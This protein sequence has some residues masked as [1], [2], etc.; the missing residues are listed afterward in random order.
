MSAIDVEKILSPVSEA[1][2]CGEDFTYNPAFLELQTVA[3]GTPERQMGDQVIPGE[4]PDWRAVK[5]KCLELF[6]STK[7]LRATMYVTGALLKMHGLTGLRDGLAVLHGMIEK[8]WDTLYPALDP[9]DNNDPT[10]RVNIIDSLSRAPFTDGDPFKFQQRLRETPLCESK[11]FGR[12]NLRDIAIA[13]GEIQPPAGT[14]PTDIAVI[15]GAFLDVDVDQLQANAQAVTESIEHIKATEAWLTDKL[16]AG[17]APNL[18]SFVGALSEISKVLTDQL[19]RRGIGAGSAESTEDGGAQGAA[20]GQQGQ[21][22]SGEIRSREDVIRVLDKAC[23]Y[24][25]RHEPSSPVPLLLMRA[26]RLASKNF[27]DIIRD[28]T[29]EAM[30]QIEVISGAASGESVDSGG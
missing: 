3:Q 6:A 28:M 27:L 24:Y 20:D 16:G 13:R 12:F 10:E 22:I 26:K 21:A 23:D 1:M 11:Q 4:D 30:A 29:P 19:A 7:D 18:S 14:T 8:Y 9:E 5:E 15:D 25:Q 17:N 2:P